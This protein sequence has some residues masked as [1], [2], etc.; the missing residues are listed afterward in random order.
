MKTVFRLMLG[1]SALAMAGC[2]QLPGASLG[3]TFGAED[4]LAAE[5]GG[6]GFSGALASEYAGLAQNQA[7]MVRWMNATAFISKAREAEGGGVPGPWSPDQLGVG[8]DASAKYDEAVSIIQANANARPEACARAQ[9]MWDQYLFILRAEGNGAN[10][11]LSSEDALAMLDEALAACAPPP[12]A[13]AA[14]DFIVYFG[15]DRSD[16]TSRA[17]APIVTAADA[18]MDMEASAVSVVGHTDTSGS[19]E[20]NQA[21]SERRARR[22]ASALSDRGVPQGAMTLAGRSELEP[23]RITGDGVREPLNRRVEITLSE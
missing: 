5:H 3:A 16:L 13:A 1:A 2:A 8:G 20:Y 17:I 19:V 22:V 11:P 21:L 10:C 4:Y 18:Y 14:S 12:A 6:A 23:A 7:D 9:A 15:F